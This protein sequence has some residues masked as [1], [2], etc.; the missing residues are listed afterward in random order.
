[1]S[2]IYL[3]E[4]VQYF[5]QNAELNIYQG[6][7][8]INLINLLPLLKLGYQYCLST[9][10]KIM[11]SYINLQGLCDN[12]EK[13]FNPDYLFNQ[14][15][16]G[17]IPVKI[18]KHD[19][20]SNNNIY[21]E[22]AI[23][24]NLV[25]KS[26]NTFELMASRYGF[27]CK[28]LLKNSISMILMFNSASTDFDPEIIDMLKDEQILSETLERI[29]NFIIKSNPKC[30]YITFEEFIVTVELMRDQ[31]DEGIDST[32][33]ELLIKRMTEDSWVELIYAIVSYSVDGIQKSVID[34]RI[35]NNEAY[36]LALK[37]KN[38][39]VIDMVKYKI[40][41]RIWIV[42]QAVITVCESLIG[43]SNIPQTIF[44]NR[45]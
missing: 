1:M 12:D 45:L 17:S 10:I 14:A 33:V 2:S 44:K 26:M 32:A 24:T 36:Y 11:E 19:P 6:R 22:E 35:Y 41:E 7:V 13:Y 9:G 27:K 37:S 4:A 20:A 16:G 21:L 29:L 43:Q 23:K 42:N 34:P 39:Q 18:F 5:F 3:Y 8:G 28:R 38:K 40:V 15:F 31:K 30:Y 25:A